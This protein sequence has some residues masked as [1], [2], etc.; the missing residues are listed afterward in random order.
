MSPILAR[1][2]EKAAGAAKDAEVEGWKSFF[3]VTALVIALVGFLAVIAY[4]FL[5]R[6]QKV[7]ERAKHLPLEDD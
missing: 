5:K 1:V 4:L 6:N 7:Y 3:S 2:A